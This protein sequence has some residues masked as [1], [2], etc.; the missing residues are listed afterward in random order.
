MSTT[1]VPL[2]DYFLGNNGFVLD[3]IISTYIGISLSNISSM[4]SHSK[5]FVQQIVFM[6]FGII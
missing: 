4:D 5:N 3:F 2:W 1:D 6:G